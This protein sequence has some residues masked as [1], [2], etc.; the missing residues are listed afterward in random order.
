M[1]PK[2]SPSS[3]GVGDLDP[4]PAP[5]DHHLV[6]GPDPV[7]GHHPD[8]GGG[9]RRGRVDDQGAVH[10]RAP[11]LDPVAP[12]PDPG[13]QVGGGVELRREHAVGRRLHQLGVG[14]VLPVDAVDLDVGQEGVEGRLVGGTDPDADVT[15]VE[16]GGAHLELEDLEGGAGVDDGVENL[17]QEE[18]VDHVA[19]EADDLR[20]GLV[21]GAHRS[22]RATSVSV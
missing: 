14:G 18:G 9:G 20:A 10:L 19:V 22:P 4:H 11:A 12:H 17:G 3:A 21:V 7:H 16:G 8:G 6:S 5:A 1:K 2:P 13:D 15:L